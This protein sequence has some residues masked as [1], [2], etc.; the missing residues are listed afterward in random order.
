MKAQA[1]PKSGDAINGAVVCLRKRSRRFSQKKRGEE[2]E[3]RGKKERERK[4]R[5]SGKEGILHGKWQ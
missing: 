2:R 4:L 1:V 3:G 5:K